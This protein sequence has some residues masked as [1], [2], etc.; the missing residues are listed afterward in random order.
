MGD[1]EDLLKQADQIDRNDPQW[2]SIRQVSGV[3][4]FCKYNTF[5]STQHS[6]IF[7][8]FTAINQFPVE[9]VAHGESSLGGAGEFA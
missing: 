5:L 9:S 7:T 2:V 3:T 1:L 6:L 8:I 4:I